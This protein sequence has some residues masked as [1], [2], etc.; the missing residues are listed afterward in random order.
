MTPTA[1]SA[2]RV[3]LR[4][5]VG[6]VESHQAGRF[7]SNVASRRTVLTGAG[8]AFGALAAA[9]LVGRWLR[10]GD[11]LGSPSKAQDLR[12]LQL[13]LQLEYTQVAFY[14]QALASGALKADLR[15]FAQ[16]ALA[17]ERAHLGAIKSALG[18][19]AGPKPRFDFGRATKHA[20]AFTTTAMKLEDT[21]VAGYNGQATNLTK[22]TLTVAATIVSVEARH[23]AWVRALVGEVAAPHPVDK[24][25]TA[26]EVVASLHEIGLKS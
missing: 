25:M 10:L 9:S 21:A 2:G 15:E 18:S 17:H 20:D 12:I 1:V 16:A 7:S 14:E 13:V 19:R 8:G 4:S 23:A 24:P 3:E 6:E 22:P 5:V 26:R 11:A